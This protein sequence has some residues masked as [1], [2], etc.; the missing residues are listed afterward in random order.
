MSDK[1]QDVEVQIG[2]ADD[3]AQ[4]AAIGYKQELRRDLTLLQVCFIWFYDLSNDII[5]VELW[6]W[7]SLRILQLCAYTPLAYRFLLF[8]S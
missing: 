4:L 1:K 8:L 2:E 3:E 7:A 5:V 6:V